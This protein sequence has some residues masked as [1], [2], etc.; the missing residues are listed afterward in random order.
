MSDTAFPC[1]INWFVWSI[2]TWNQADS[3]TSVAQSQPTCTGWT[4]GIAPQ[5]MHLPPAVIPLRGRWL[6]P[7]RYKTT[8]ETVKK[9][10]RNVHIAPAERAKPKAVPRRVPSSAVDGREGGG[11]STVFFFPIFAWCLSVPMTHKVWRS[12]F[13]R[14]PRNLRDI[15]WHGFALFKK[16]RHLCKTPR[17]ILNR[18]TMGNQWKPCPVAKMDLEGSL[19]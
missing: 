18:E 12:E 3:P 13:L 11:R 17:R 8:P 1:H 14:W 15:F 10:A 9:N 2:S 4:N 16:E 7:I 5:D 6:P 19:W